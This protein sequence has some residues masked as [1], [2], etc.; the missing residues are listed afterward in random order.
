MKVS[1]DFEA[2]IDEMEKMLH[3]L[4][5]LQKESG[6]ELSSQINELEEKLH[7]RRGNLFKFNP[8]ANGSD[9]TPSSKTGV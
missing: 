6:G 3:K 2:P 1:L 5:E 8:M 4:K 9:C 7:K